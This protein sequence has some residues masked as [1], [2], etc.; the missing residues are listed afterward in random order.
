VFFRPF[1]HDSERVPFCR[2][3]VFG[4]YL[5]RVKDV[6]V[7]IEEIAAK[8]LHEA[9]SQRFQAGARIS[10]CHWRLGSSD[11]SGRMNLRLPAVRRKGYEKI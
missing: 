4:T 10:L 8:F 1:P 3:Q 2:I 9:P 5:C 11:V 6:I 7:I